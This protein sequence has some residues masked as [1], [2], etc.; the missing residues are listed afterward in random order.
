MHSKPFNN[1]IWAQ[2]TDKAV[3]KEALQNT[4]WNIESIPPLNEL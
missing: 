2:D 1:L 3:V 4:Q